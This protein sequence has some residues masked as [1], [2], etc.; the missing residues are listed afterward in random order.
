MAQ[1]IE[2]SGSIISSSCSWSATPV[3]FIFPSG[4]STHAPLV[5]SSV[6]K[7]D[8]NVVYR[9]SYDK[10]TGD[11]GHVELNTYGL[12]SNLILEKE[13]EKRKTKPLFDRITRKH[14]SYST[15]LLIFVINHI[16]IGKNIKEHDQYQRNNNGDFR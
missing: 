11:Y 9:L 7:S 15:K 16:V 12:G 8:N 5:M 4:A 6:E 2:S 1:S 13:H 3:D 14:S 10:E